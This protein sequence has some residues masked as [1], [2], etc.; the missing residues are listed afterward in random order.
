MA[1]KSENEVRNKAREFEEKL[2]KN[3]VNAEVLD[4]TVRDYLIKLRIT[5]GNTSGL[6]S[7]YHKPSKDT[8]SLKTAGIKDD[9]LKKKM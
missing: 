7:I 5:S 1:Y 3:S 2:I 9:E 4:D 8:F 6:I